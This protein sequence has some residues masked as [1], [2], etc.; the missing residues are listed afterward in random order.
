[1]RGLGFRALVA[2]QPADRKRRAAAVLPRRQFF[3]QGSTI[4]FF[5]SLDFALQHG[6]GI[7]SS[8]VFLVIGFRGFRSPGSFGFS[9]DVGR[10]VF[11]VWI[12]R[13]SDRIWIW[14]VFVC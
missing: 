6:L 9:E 1:L 10:L 7:G 13:F 14:I 8:T 11:R 12:I 2:A 5:R 4:G 3:C